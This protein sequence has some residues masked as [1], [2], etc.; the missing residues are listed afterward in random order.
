MGEVGL[1]NAG[2]KV[3]YGRGPGRDDKEGGGLPVQHRP[4]PGKGTRGGRAPNTGKKWHVGRPG[5]KGEMDQAQIN[6]VIS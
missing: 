1:D 2:R 6:N 5:R 3:H 4:K